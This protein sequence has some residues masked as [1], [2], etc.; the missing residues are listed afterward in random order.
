M[1]QL[2]CG[3]PQVSGNTSLPHSLQ[4]S[5]R[6]ILLTIG[7]GIVTL[8][9]L[10][11]FF[12]LCSPVVSTCNLLSVVHPKQNCLEHSKHSLQRAM[13]VTL[14]EELLLVNV[15]WI[16]PFR[17][18]HSCPASLRDCSPGT[19]WTAATVHG[20][21]TRPRCGGWSSTT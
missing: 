4:G 5:T 20:F 9:D 19:S 15:L 17:L 14:P 6:C 3:R 11:I 1:L 12:S 8:H 18:S 7:F 10:L 21:L 13:S 16:W 2:P